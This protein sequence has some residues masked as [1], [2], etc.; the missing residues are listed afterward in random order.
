MATAASARKVRRRDPAAIYFAFFLPSADAYVVEVHRL[1][2]AAEPL[3]QCAPC[4][5]RLPPGEA[6]LYIFSGAFIS[7]AH[8]VSGFCVF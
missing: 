3:P 4:S 6:V 1:R 8:I 5:R 2:P 7:I